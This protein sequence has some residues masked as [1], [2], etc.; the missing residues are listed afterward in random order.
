MAHAA[1]FDAVEKMHALLE[2]ATLI[3]RG[4]IIT[5]AA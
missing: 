3:G 5:G 2:D 4:E 1:K